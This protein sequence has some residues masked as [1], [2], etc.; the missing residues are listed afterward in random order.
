MQR[1]FGFGYRANNYENNKSDDNKVKY[2]LQPCSPQNSNLGSN[3]CYTVFCENRRTDDSFD[4]VKAAFLHEY[5]DEGVD[6]VGNESR[7]DLVECTAD[8]NCDSKVKNVAAHY[9]FAEI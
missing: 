1:L 3:H 4:G 5:T 9:E 8:Y 6:N 7:Y 2:R